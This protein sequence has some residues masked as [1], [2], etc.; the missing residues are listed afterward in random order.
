MPLHILCVQ[1]FAID[2]ASRSVQAPF[3]C[4]IGQEKTRH[5]KLLL[6]FGTKLSDA[7]VIQYNNVLLNVPGGRETL[8]IRGVVSILQKRKCSDM[9]YIF[10]GLTVFQIAYKCL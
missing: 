3:Y 8:Q 9:H 1:L 2:H 7:S 5:I 4:S 6:V 10:T